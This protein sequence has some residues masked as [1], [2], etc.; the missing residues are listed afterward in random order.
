MLPLECKLDRDAALEKS[1]L[2]ER[3]VNTTSNL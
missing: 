1:V 2:G 3:P